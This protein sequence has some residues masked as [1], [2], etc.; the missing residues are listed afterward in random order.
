MD[1]NQLAFLKKTLI[2]VQVFVTWNIF[3][4]RFVSISIFK[5]RTSLAPSG[6]KTKE[7]KKKKR[8]YGVLSFGRNL[9]IIRD[10]QLQLDIISGFYSSILPFLR[11]FFSW[12]LVHLW[13]MD[14]IA[15]KIKLLDWFCLCPQRSGGHGMGNA[16]QWEQDYRLLDLN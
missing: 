14:E 8:N 13:F 9:P 10:Y 6:K 12:F 11:H 3:R 4:L 5:I 7:K 15:P 16:F 2:I 1:D